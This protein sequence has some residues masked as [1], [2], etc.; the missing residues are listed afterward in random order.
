MNI[1]ITDM[2]NLTLSELIPDDGMTVKQFDLALRALECKLL[3]IPA[4]IKEKNKL[5]DFTS[6]CNEEVMIDLDSMTTELYELVACLRETLPALPQ[7][8]K[9]QG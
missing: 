9:E 5:V 7:P 1:D 4:K 2:S 8:P 3:K 6:G